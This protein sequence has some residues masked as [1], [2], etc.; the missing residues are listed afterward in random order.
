LV[1]VAEAWA[2]LAAESRIEPGWHTRRVHAGSA[3][4][5]R[6][7]VRA[8]DG[9]LAVLFEVEAKSIPPG[10]K[11][12]NCVGFEVTLETISPG[13][14]GRVRL[15]LVLKDQRYRDVFAQNPRWDFG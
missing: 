4:D 11:L 8:P 15:C 5:I 1:A 2:V 7:A 9:A 14:G 12:P 10:A 3:C 6:S 13:P